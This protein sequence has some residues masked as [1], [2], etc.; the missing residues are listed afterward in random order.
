MMVVPEG[1]SL[2]QHNMTMV[3][4][5]HTGVEHSIP[6]SKIY[7][8]VVQLWKQS[9]TGYTPTL[10]VG[11]GGIW[12]ENYWYAKT[13]VW[14]NE[15]L[16]H[17]VPRQIVD[18]RS[19]RPFSA[20]DE[21]YGFLNN[22][23]VAKKLHDAGVNV[24]LGAHGQREG[25]GVQWELCMLQMGGMTPH[26]ALR[27]GTLEGAR[28]LGLDRDIGSLEPGKLA[29]LVVLD[30]NPLDDIR[31]AEKVHWTVVNGRVY[32]AMKMDEVGNRP[33]PRA[34]FFFEGNAGAL[35]SKT[36]MED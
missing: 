29:D 20:P 10:I 34:K 33:K 15:R 8:D 4:D 5:G 24:Q 27:C 2:F 14:E 11:Y 7:Q 16:L 17:F 6:V 26:E 23:R 32:D 31:N 19:R 1:G 13:H 25:L 35:P 36:Q 21:E 30:A 22:A 28:Y 9:K 12:G 3:I 18:A